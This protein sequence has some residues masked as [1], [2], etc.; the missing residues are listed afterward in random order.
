MGF[1]FTLFPY[2]LLLICWRTLNICLFHNP[3]SPTSD[4][5]FLSSDVICVGNV[6]VLTVEDGIFKKR[7][8]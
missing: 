2:L 7:L 8:Q 3:R 1:F 6:F 4:F 5:F